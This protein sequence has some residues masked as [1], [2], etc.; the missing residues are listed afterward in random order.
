MAGRAHRG[1]GG[2]RQLSTARDIDTVAL[3][4]L[5]VAAWLPDEVA[6]HR[7]WLLRAAGGFTGRGN[8]ALVLVDPRGSASGD[9]LDDRLAD[10]ERWYAAR[11]LPAML[12]VPLPRFAAIARRAGERGWTSGHGGRVL[13]ADLARLRDDAATS[14]TPGAY[15]VGVADDLD[16]AWLQRY[17]PRAGSLPDAGRR[18][19]A[20]GDRVAFAAARSRDGD[21]VAIG[22]GVVVD[23]WLGVNAV[24]TVPAHRRRGLATRILAVLVAWARAHGATRAFLQVDLSND[25]AH[26][27]YRTAGFVDHHTYRYVLG[28]RAVSRS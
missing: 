6:D 19:L 13:V 16:P 15:L 17:H 11:H 25:V 1:A 9:D 28:P 4:R 24:E 14:A 18:M 10:V 2:T 20:R 8:S 3:E 22:R 23:G 21:V 5:A 26:A 7:G 12:A 27:V